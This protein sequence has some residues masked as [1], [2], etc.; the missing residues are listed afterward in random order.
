MVTK[1]VPRYFSPEEQA[2]MTAFAHQAA[3]AIANARLFEQARSNLQQVVEAN[4]RLEELD[5]LR[6]EYLRNVSHEFRTPLTVIKGYSEF[7]L[8]SNPTGTLHEAMTVLA[9]SCDRMIDL[10]ET[11]IEV[12]RIEQG[13]G[14]RVLQ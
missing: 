2:L 13:E 7:I 6:R 11:L 4:R 10:V 5:R 3:V 8:E 9:E 1:G 14:E 12:G